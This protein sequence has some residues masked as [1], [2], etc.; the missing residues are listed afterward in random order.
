[1][2]EQRNAKDDCSLHQVVRDFF[3]MLNKYDDEPR[4]LTIYRSFIRQFIRFKTV[5]NALPVIEVMSIF[6]AERP[7]L[8]YLLKKDQT[9]TFHFLTHID[10]DEHIARDRVNKFLHQKH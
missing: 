8:F 2:I 4:Y 7:T 9:A 6:K 3:E 5:D 1:M 10:L